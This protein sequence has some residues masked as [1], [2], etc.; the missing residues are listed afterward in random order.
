MISHSGIVGVDSIRWND[1][2]WC[3]QCLHNAPAL[4]SNPPCS[5]RSQTCERATLKR[6]QD[7]FIE[8][9]QGQFVPLSHVL[10][11]SSYRICPLS[12]ASLRWISL[13]M[14][15]PYK[16][17]GGVKVKWDGLFEVFQ[18]LQYFILSYASTKSTRGVVNV[19]TIKNKAESKWEEMGL[20]FDH[21]LSH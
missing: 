5:Q 4:S 20:A 16:E 8:Y 10:I 14:F 9:D 12:N 13:T 19:P 7:L 18:A 1:F 17:Y 15:K 6:S 11:S 2:S 3:I 21:F